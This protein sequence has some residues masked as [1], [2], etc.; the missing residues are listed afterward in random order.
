MTVWYTL[1]HSFT[2]AGA[3]PSREGAE[4]YRDPFSL[5]VLLE[6]ILQ[7]TLM[8]YI[9]LFVVTEEFLCDDYIAI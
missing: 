5:N 3:I 7:I 6:S 9:V 2:H 1:M 4:V 8:S